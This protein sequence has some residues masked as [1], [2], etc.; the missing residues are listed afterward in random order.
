M[1]DFARSIVEYFV[2]RRG[3]LVSADVTE[4]SSDGIVQKL[5][6]LESST[7]LRVTMRVVRP[8]TAPGQTLPVIVEESSATR[9][10]GIFGAADGSQHSEPTNAASWAS[11]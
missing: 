8:A 2:E 1:P 11:S 9:S 7:G 3:T 5:V 6:L 10:V 4:A